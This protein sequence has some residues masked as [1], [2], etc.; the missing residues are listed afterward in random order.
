[1]VRALDSRPEGLDFTILAPP[2]GRAPHSLRNADVYDTYT[3]KWEEASEDT[4]GSLGMVSLA[5]WKPLNRAHRWRFGMADRMSKIAIWQ[6]AG[7][8][9][10]QDT[11]IGEMIQND[12]RAT[13]RNLVKAGTEQHIVSDV[14]QY[15]KIVL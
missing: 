9:V 15:S 2:R 4:T 6:E 11:R 14:L 10:L 1:M 5:K 3:L 8:H 7:G 13:E 12:R